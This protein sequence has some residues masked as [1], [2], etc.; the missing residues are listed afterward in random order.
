MPDNLAGAFQL[1]RGNRR[2]WV[3]ILYVLNT[4][5]VFVTNNTTLSDEKL[6]GPHPLNANRVD[7]SKSY[8]KSGTLQ[9]EFNKTGTLL[10]ARFGKRYT[11]FPCISRATNTRSNEFRECANIGAFVCVSR[12][13]RGV[14]AALAQR[15]VAFVASNACALESSTSRKACLELRWSG[16]VPVERGVDWRKWSR[17]GDGGMRGHSSECV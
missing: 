5:R 7:N 17:G 6:Q 9:L 14:L 11:L 13:R 1:A 10:L 15:V 4:H 16:N 3:L 2:P 12:S 8:P